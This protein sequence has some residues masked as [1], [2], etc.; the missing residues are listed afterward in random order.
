MNIN[1]SDLNLLAVFH[2]IARELNTTRAAKT[3]NLSQPAVSHALGRLRLM[4][5]DPL[6]VRASRGLIPTVKAQEL[7][8]PI[9][10]ILEKAE[11]LLREVSF[12]PA[13]EERVFRI[14]TT[15][16]FEVVALPQILKKISQ[17]APGIQIITRPT[18]GELQKEAF[19][20][21][22]LDLAI[23]GY[24]GELPEGYFQQTVFKDEFICVGRKGHPALKGTLTPK[25][26]SMARHILISPH[27]DMKS[28][29]SVALKKLK[30]EQ[31]FQA[32]ISSFTA[33]GWIVADS[34]LLLTCPMKLAQ[35]Y[36][37]YLPVEEGKLPFS[38]NGINVVQVWHA[39][40]H[41][42]QAHAWLRNLIK[43]CCEEL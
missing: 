20:K 30:F 27:G 26:Y 38:L 9:G 3:L 5:N 4:F 11:S 36:K 13:T 39:R 29:S 1:T 15:D 42:D 22:E 10:N 25:K 7:M 41:K 2:A 16:Y 17:I 31:Y 19:E 28:R 14:S 37:K 35:A 24:F 32:G 12:N 8:G 40:H 6:F 18:Q 21:G 34:D 33:P 43:E 23:A